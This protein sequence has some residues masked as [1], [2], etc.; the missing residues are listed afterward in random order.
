MFGYLN[1]RRKTDVNTLLKTKDLK[2]AAVN[3]YRAVI[4]SCGGIGLM[5]TLICG[6]DVQVVV[7]FVSVMV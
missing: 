2:R 1:D 3:I 7:L 4:L 5:V 6:A